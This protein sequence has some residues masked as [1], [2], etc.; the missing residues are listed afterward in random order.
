VHLKI[1]VTAVWSLFYFILF[2]FIL[3]Y[4]HANNLMARS[5]VF[6]NPNTLMEQT[7]YLNALFS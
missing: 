6:L 7:L 3:F 1:K 4:F 5:A 2:H